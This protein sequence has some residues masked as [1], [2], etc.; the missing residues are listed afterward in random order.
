MRVSLQLPPVMIEPTLVRDGLKISMDRLK[1]NY[2]DLYLLHNAVSIDRDYLKTLRTSDAKFVRKETAW[3]T[4]TVLS[5]QLLDRPWRNLMTPWSFS[6][7]W[8]MWLCGR[9]GHAKLSDQFLVPSAPLFLQELEKLVDEGLVRNI[10]VSNFNQEQIQNLID[11]SRI[12]PSVLQVC[13]SLRK[14]NRTIYKNNEAHDSSTLFI[15]QTLTPSSR[16]QYLWLHV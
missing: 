4:Q 10:G 11:H 5:T 6:G 1:L 14:P 2:V 15:R 13:Q 9:Y 3:L 16:H 7:M 12:K 8:I